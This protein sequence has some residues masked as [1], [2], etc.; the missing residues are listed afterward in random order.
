MADLAQQQGEGIPPQAQLMQMSMGFMISGL[1][2][3]AVELKLAD[4]L[5]AGPKTAE[6]LA[7]DT[8][9]HAP[10]LYRMMRTL[11]AHGVFAED[12]EK[13]F[14]L[15]PLGEPLRTDVPGSIWSSLMIVTGGLFAKP[16]ANLK[17]SVETG[18][19]AF[20]NLYGMG[21]FEYLG[22][23]PVDAKM[24]SDL[25]VGFHGG[26]PPAV[27]E[28]YDFSGLGTIADVGGATGNLL[29]TVLAKY[30]EAT[31]VIYDLPHNAAG[32]A[33]FVKGRG[34]SDRVSFQA[35]SFFESIP[36]G[37]D[38]YIMS[39]IIHDWS[40]EECL[41]ILGNCKKAMKPGSRLLI[42]EMVLPEGNVFHPGKMTD[43]IMLTIPGGQERTT[44]EYRELLAK[45]GFRLERVVGTNSA[46]SVV[47][48][49][50]V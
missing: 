46:A 7:K 49:V 3:T 18:E 45:A 5:A 48:A 25:M 11:S 40:E 8:G 37:F 42:V 28:A 22:K 15:T 10:S 14:T 35:G 20:E 12:D 34:M 47:E 16:F 23:H 9:T 43:M 39:H 13:R 17:Y 32:A 2:G 50:V 31:G 33:E 21:I 44:T 30:P 41:T 27:A 4:H 29:T 1:L 24:F 6:E 26:E 38:V 36:A 19:T